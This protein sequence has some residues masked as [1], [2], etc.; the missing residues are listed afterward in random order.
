[1]KNVF[2]VSQKEKRKLEEMADIM[3][4][5]TYNFNVGTDNND[6]DR[7][8]TREEFVNYAE[9][10]KTGS[11]PA[12]E[13]EGFDL[14]IGSRYCTYYDYGEH[15]LRMLNRAVTFNELCNFGKYVS[16]NRIDNA[17]VFENGKEID[18]SMREFD[19]C[20]YKQLYNGGIRYRINYT[21]LVTEKDVVKAFDDDCVVKIYISK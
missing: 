18:M 8:E 3:C 19:E 13:S 17:T 7:C 14:K 12:K 5:V 4:C 11:K 6:E 20:F 21:L 10:F 1:M 2:V 16:F 9:G 15:L